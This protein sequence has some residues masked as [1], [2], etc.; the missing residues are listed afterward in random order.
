MRWRFPLTFVFAV[1][2]TAGCDTDS[3]TSLDADEQAATPTFA[4]QNAN[5]VHDLW[6]WNGQVVDVCGLE[7]VEFN[8]RIFARIRFMEDGNGGLHY[9]LNENV[10]GT[11]VGLSSGNEWILNN[12]NNVQSNWHDGGQDEYTWINWKGEYISKGAMPN[13]SVIMK[14]RWV[15]DANG[16]LRVYREQEI[17]CG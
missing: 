16:V 12:K 11:G 13:F 14:G 9:T 5:V 3:P 8:L 4:S 17:N 7:D 6:E 15:F 2:V 1:L 10:H